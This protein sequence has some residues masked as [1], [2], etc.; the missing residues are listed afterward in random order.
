MVEG[1]VGNGWPCGQDAISRTVSSSTICSYAVS[2]RPWNGGTSSLRCL[3]CSSPASANS[4]PEP[5]TRPRFWSRLSTVSA[6]VVNSC[7]ISPG[8]LITTARPK[9]GTLTVKA[10]P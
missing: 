2:R 1:S 6:P 7:L 9:I 5:S 3:R 10:S 4:D 8:S